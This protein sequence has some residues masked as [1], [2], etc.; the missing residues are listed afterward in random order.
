MSDTKVTIKFKCIV[1]GEVRMS[2]DE[3]ALSSTHKA[4]PANS[5]VDKEPVGLGVSSNPTQEAT[6]DYGPSAP[7]EYGQRQEEVDAGSTVTSIEESSMSSSPSSDNHP[8]LE[9]LP[10]AESPT[11]QPLEMAKGHGENHASPKGARDGQRR[12]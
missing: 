10:L 4:D 7:H 9:I 8:A 12:Q 2:S 6:K 5:T 1:K 3:P 11:M